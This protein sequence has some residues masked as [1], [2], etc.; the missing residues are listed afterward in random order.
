MVSPPR[1]AV[2]TLLITFFFLSHFGYNSGARLQRED[3]ACST[4]CWT[5]PGGVSQMRIK[6][7]RCCLETP[8]EALLQRF[9][10][11]WTQ[12]LLIFECCCCCCCCC[13]CCCCCCCCCFFS[14]SSSSSS[15][16]GLAHRKD[17]IR[18]QTPC[19]HYPDC[20]TT[21]FSSYGSSLNQN[22]RNHQAEIWYP[23]KSDI[24]HPDTKQQCSTCQLSKTRSWEAMNESPDGRV[25]EKSWK[26][27]NVP[28]PYP[29]PHPKNQKLGWIIRVLTTH[30]LRS[31]S[32]KWFFPPFW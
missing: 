25:S 18:K 32:K 9:V 4:I 8:G 29:N 24:S 27:L 14:S 13:R 23:S 17:E 15:P 26:W 11:I 1:S 21:V 19:C 16:R 6:A 7:G 22:I 10:L 3:S 12:L 31:S 30:I 28:Q 5:L 20:Q 2:I